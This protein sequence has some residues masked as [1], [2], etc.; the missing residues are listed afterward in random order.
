MTSIYPSALSCLPK[1]GILNGKLLFLLYPEHL[2]E[3]HSQYDS[4]IVHGVTNFMNLVKEYMELSC[5][6]VDEVV[7][8]DFKSC[9]FKAYAY[10]CGIYLAFC[11]ISGSNIVRDLHEELLEG[12]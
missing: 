2:P 1:T 3:E 10:Q 7:L 6:I 12:I 8:E 5:H 9:L 11:N 4:I